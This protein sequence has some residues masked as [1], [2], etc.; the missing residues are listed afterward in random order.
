MD[1]HLGEAAGAE[2]AEPLVGG[3]RGAALGAGGLH[4]YLIQEEF[5]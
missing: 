1:G 5:M 4:A 2:P 3:A